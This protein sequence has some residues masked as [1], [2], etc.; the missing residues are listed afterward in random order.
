MCQKERQKESQGEPQSATAAR[1]RKK[2]DLAE[3]KRYIADVVDKKRQYGVHQTAH[4]EKM[5][6]FLSPREIFQKG[7]FSIMKTLRLRSGANAGVP[8]PKRNVRL[9]NG[10]FTSVSYERCRKLGRIY[11]V[12]SR[13]GNQGSHQRDTKRATWC[14]KRPLATDDDRL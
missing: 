10:K 6:Q 9:C 13:G 3:T 5:L 7:P 12:R 1:I 2:G 14:Q 11:R 4:H 8:E